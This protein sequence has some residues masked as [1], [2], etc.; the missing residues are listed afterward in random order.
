MYMCVP[1]FHSRFCFLL[2]L[3]T[4]I[5]M[6]SLS[7]YSSSSYS[8][9]YSSSSSSAYSSSSSSSSFSFLILLLSP[10]GHISSE[11]EAKNYEKILTFQNS[12]H[13]HTHRRHQ[14]PE[15]VAQETTQWAQSG[16]T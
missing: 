4:S 1:F 3:V 11:R 10:S 12:P 6:F 13:L 5:K 7:S 16:V 15:A 8:S 14:I 9:A 2:L